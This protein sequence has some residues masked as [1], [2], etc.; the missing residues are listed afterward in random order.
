MSFVHLHVHT[1][2]SLLE[3]TIRAKSL[4]QAAAADSMPAVAVTDYGNMFGAIE[5]YFAA[6]SAG[7][8]PIIGL[9]AY[10]AP[11]SRHVKGE[12]R[13]VVQMPNRRIVLLAQNFK[14]YQNLCKISSI[15]YKEGFYYRP[16][17]DYEVLE[18]HSSD[19]IAL[20]GGVMGE[21]PWNFI[22]K[23]A[24]E[25][26]ERIKALKN[27]YG[28]RLYLEMNRTGV[29]AWDEINPFLQE[30]SQIM[31][32]PLVAAN[33]IHYLKQ[34]DQLAQEVLICIGSNK[35]LQD[36]TRYKL[37]TDQFYFKN[38]EQMRTLFKDLPEAC[39]RTL[40]VA[41]RCNLQFQ[42]EDPEGKPIYYLPTFPTQEGETTSDE[43]KRLSMEGLERRFQ[44]AEARGELIS[45]EEKQKYFERLEFELKVIEGMGFNGYFLIVQDFINWAKKCDIPVGPGRGSGAGSLVAYSLYITDLN[46]MPYNL[47]FERFLNP[48]RISM[49]DFDIDF[50]QENRGRVIDYVTEKYG[51]DSVSQIITYGKLQARAAIRDVGRVLGMT[52]SEVDIVAKL[53]PEKLGITLDEAIEMEPRIREMME[54]DPK[55][56][57]LMD[58]A[59]NIEG[60]VRHAGIH[61]AGV[62]IAEGNLVDHAPLYRGVEGE[63]VVQ[64]DM[65]HSE[66]IGLIKF[67]F[68]GLKTLTHINDALKLI[69]KNRN[70]KITTNEISLK[71][72]GIY[73]IMAKG[74]TAGIFQF[75]GDGITDLI[76][77]AKPS[78]FEDIVALNALYRPGPMDMIPSY[79][80]RKHGKV[81][82]DYIFPELEPILKET[83]GIVIYQEHVQLIAAKIASY[84]LGE[85]DMLRRAM[86]K[87]IAEEMAKQKSRFL[88]GAKKNGY[89]EEKSE[90]LFETMAEFAKYGF[91]KS[92]AAAYCVIA[93][94]TAWLK[95]YYPVEFFAAL[96]STEMNDTDK[97]VKYVKD[98]QKHNIHVQ[99][100]HINHSEFKFNVKGDEIF[101]SLGAIKGVGRSAVEAILEAREL[102]P[103]Q[104]FESLED[105]FKSIDLRRVNKKTIESL[106]K[107]GAF[108]GFG[109][110]RAELM[111][112]YPQFIERADRIRKDN[113]MGQVSLFSLDEKVSEQEN[114]HL[115]KK[116]PWRRSYRLAA[117]KE[118]LGFYLSDHPL[119]GLEALTQIWSTGDVE[120]L[121]EKE[122]KSRVEIVGLISSMREIIT[123]KG[124]R[125]AFASFEDLTGSVEL[126]VFPDAFK[127]FELVL[128]SEEALIV[129]GSLEKE[130]DSLKIFVDEVRTVDDVYKKAKKLVFH[131]EPEMNQKM[132]SLKELIE[133]FPGDTS[134]TIEMNLK[135]IGQK[136]SIEIKDPKGVRPS[137]EFFENIHNL[138]GSTQVVEFQAH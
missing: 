114:V 82:I 75:E 27:I 95:N 65:K 127:D 18:A 98:A 64:Y 66:K 91:N 21:V 13:D 80:D 45:E 3:A 105:F 59:R 39:D 35:T 6:R 123:K 104:A 102:K 85:A 108:D 68:L 17:I 5:F 7:V 28:D 129:S 137:N 24:D 136:V 46:P 77:K 53:M 31:D 40:E 33:D 74:D 55:I 54:T 15:G 30:A 47:I 93:A 138:F 58:L 126:I 89:D 90:K 70:K 120:H 112:G 122:N 73:S 87:K 29:K 23:G 25:A 101:F 52:F 50:C 134:V 118:V 57:T 86:G 42:L 34:E 128:K 109:F 4:A 83:Y 41:D 22:N 130:Q 100:P 113:E 116:S 97:V 92:H 8:K 1:Q 117:E 11:G 2:Y 49:P 132:E 124:T 103:N 76:K 81:A 16:R 131:I 67:D 20:T 72:A 14:G 115:E 119:K 38:S 125:M 133:K 43:M 62:I 26:L 44:E 36:E 107:A 63:N 51:Q 32:I 71:D 60:L 84:S 37:G 9:E 61:A 94:Q 19:L 56:Q 111:D 110:N 69:E 96:L 121:L 79:L 12:G 135:D 48:E 106:I 78:E 88:S 10:I 99:S